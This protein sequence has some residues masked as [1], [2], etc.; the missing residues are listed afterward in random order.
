MLPGGGFVSGDTTI[1]FL[2]DGVD[3]Q[4]DVQL[5]TQVVRV[6]LLSTVPVAI[7]FAVTN[8]LSPQ[9]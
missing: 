8:L 5:G 9:L 4:R 1:L 3:V 7:K 6:C 2:S